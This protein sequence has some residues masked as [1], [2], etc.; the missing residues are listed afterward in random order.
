MKLRVWWIPQVPM[1]RSF[2]VPVN[3]VEEGVKILN[4]LGD[5]DLFQLNTNIKGDYSNAGG[6]EMF[7][8]EDKED[9]P[10][11]SWVSW[12]DEETGEDDPEAFLKEQSNI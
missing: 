2:L 8:P 11:G 6:L 1:N 9:G 5:Y 12:S 4:V 7:D 3:S 10:D